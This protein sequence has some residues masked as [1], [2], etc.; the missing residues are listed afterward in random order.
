[1]TTLRTSLTREIVYTYRIVE[2]SIGDNYAIQ[3]NPI[4][5]LQRRCYTWSR[6][7]QETFIPTYDL[8]ELTSMK[9]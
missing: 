4:P 3:V 1:M 5:T 7:H 8:A 9:R 6:L 2:F